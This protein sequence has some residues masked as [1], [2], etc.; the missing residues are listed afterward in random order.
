MKVRGTPLFHRVYQAVGQLKT[1]VVDGIELV[2]PRWRIIFLRGG[3]RSSKSFTVMQIMT[4]WLYTGWMGDRYVPEGNFTVVRATFPSLR[5]T[6]LKDF[7]EYLF[8]QGIYHEI[9]YRKTHHE[10]YYGKRHI[11]FISADDEQKLRGRKHKFAWLEEIND[12]KFDVFTQIIMRLDEQVFMTVNPSGFPWGK[13][14]IEEKRQA[15]VGDVHVDVSTYL[16]NPFLDNGVVTEIKNL[17]FL[18]A[19]LFRIYTKG[20]WTQMKGLIYKNYEINYTP[21]VG[22]RVL[23]L[24]FGFTHPAAIIEVVVIGMDAYVHEHFYESEKLPSDLIKFIKDSGLAGARIIADRSR[25]EA[26]R[27]MKNA[28]LR[29]KRS[30]GEKDSVFTGINI[31]KQYH[32]HFSASS[33]NLL[34]EVQRYKWAEDKDGVQKDEPI[35]M[36]DDGMDAMRY[37][38]VNIHKGGSRVNFI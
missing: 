38:V 28:G 31:V 5:A 24:D 36:W 25:P 11:D 19:D 14:E 10:F 22:R 21:P 1:K 37:A 23:G 9:E 35:K 17:E 15:I 34:K 6:V 12:M 2:V 4:V 29:I 32:L 7:I 27:E 13:T 8:D 16:D 33:V 3:A 20:E 26:I 18:D 30:P